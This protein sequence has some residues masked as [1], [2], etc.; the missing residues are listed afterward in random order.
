M[1]V[2]IVFL[3][4]FV[5][6]FLGIPL[7]VCTALPSILPYTVNA[8]FAG[9]YQFV[10]RAVV[11]ALDSTSLIAIPLFML[12]GSIMAR[13]GL[14][15]R[16]FDVFAYF[17]GEISAGM[18]C[19]VIVTCLFYGA[20]SG[21]GPATVAA[22]GTMCIPILVNLGY[23]KIF[24]TAL[25]AVAGGLGVIIPPSIPFI[26]YGTSCGVSV[27]DLF[28]AGVIPGILVAVLLM[29]YAFIYCKRHG[30]DKE[31]LHAN[32]Q[33]LKEKGLFGVLKEGF[34]ALLT[35]IIILGGIYSGIVT[36]TES[37]CISIFYAIFVCM[38]FYKSM[39]FKDLP[40][41]MAGAVKSYG[42]MCLLLGFGG[43]FGK[44]LNLLHA[45]DIISSAVT[46][47]ISSK[48][49]FLLLINLV[50]L[51]LGMVGETTS[52]IVIMGPVFLEAA[53]AYGVDP[54]HFGVI[55]IVNLAIGLIT[56]PIGVNLFVAAPLVDEPAMKIAKAAVP[57]MVMMLIALALITYIPQISLVFIS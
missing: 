9:N 31:K 47:A 25:V 20:I 49:V 17:I 29:A 52:G 43:A 46:G 7:A 19:A 42:P 11:S 15:K 23:D 34:W 33:K 57:F 14:S 51:F 28:L 30:E 21:S 40:G 22:V 5:M 54:I 18:P 37:A 35:P 10:L 56:P 38:V 45:P 44:I 39:S 6:I 55:L 8:A 13:G 12:S 50:F 1:M 3:V 16:L 48:I 26:V 24:A 41:F 2:G 4:F 36:P 32:H 27:G 53:I